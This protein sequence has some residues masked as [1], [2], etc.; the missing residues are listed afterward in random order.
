[1]ACTPFAVSAIIPSRPGD[2]N[3]K[4]RA[5]LVANPDRLKPDKKV[6][7]PRLAIAPRWAGRL[8]LISQSRLAGP[9]LDT[10]RMVIHLSTPLARRGYA[11][12]NQESATKHK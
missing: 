11:A 12:S 1:M 5:L 8:K 4:S 9:C 10:R 7:N 2:L 6:H 3:P